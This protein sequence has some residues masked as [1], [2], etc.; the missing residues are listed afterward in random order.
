MKTLDILRA[1]RVLIERALTQGYFA[2]DADGEECGSLSESAVCWCAIGAAI[3][4]DPPASSFA[5]ER[6]L[7]MALPEEF[8]SAS[9]DPADDVAEFNDTP[10]RAKE[11]VLALYDRAIAAQEAL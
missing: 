11:E 1:A 9:E 4:A 3:R 2:H 6:A 7:W 8:R 10:G 5:A